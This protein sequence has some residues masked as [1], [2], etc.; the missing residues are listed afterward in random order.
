[1]T[2]KCT[3]FSVDSTVSSAIVVPGAFSL[4]FERGPGNEVE[5][6]AFKKHVI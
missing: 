1:M 3:F 5:F 6:L 4:K 2:E